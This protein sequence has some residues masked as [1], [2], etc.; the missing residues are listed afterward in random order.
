MILTKQNKKSRI[1]KKKQEIKKKIQEKQLE[2]RNAKKT[3]DFLPI[4]RERLD[5][6]AHKECNGRDTDTQNDNHIET[7]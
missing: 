4:P 2:T 3:L 6:L 7:Y 1:F 5:D